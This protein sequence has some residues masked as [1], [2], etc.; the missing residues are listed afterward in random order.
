MTLT[1]G[2]LL[3]ACIVP[4]TQGSG[5]KT[6]GPPIPAHC[7]QPF[8]S[9]LLSAQVAAAEFREVSWGLTHGRP[10]SSCPLALGVSLYPIFYGPEYGLLT[11]LSSPSGA[12]AQKLTL[13]ST[14]NVWII[15][16]VPGTSFPPGKTSGSP[17]SPKLLLTPSPDSLC[18]PPNYSYPVETTSLG[19][20]LH[21]GT[22]AAS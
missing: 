15:M 13:S 1:V 5:R 14:G 22:E 4:G 8:S 3:G 2:H 17:P 19:S 10:F 16:L 9:L 7:P 6:C 11:Q 20:G 21:C 12:L 18:A